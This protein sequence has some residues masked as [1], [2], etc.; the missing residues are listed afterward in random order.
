MTLASHVGSEA[1][2]LRRKAMRYG[3]LAAAYELPPAMIL[4]SGLP[5]S[6]KSWMAQHLSRPL[7]GGHPAK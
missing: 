2:D 1:L 7:A 4:M 3:Q 6:G 5:A